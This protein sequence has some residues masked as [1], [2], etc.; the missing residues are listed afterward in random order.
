MNSVRAFVPLLLLCLTP[1]QMDGRTRAAA[2]HIDS[3]ERI[4]V[5]TAHP[6]DELVI[7]P[8]LANRCVHGGA[9]CALL[10]MT[11][12]N[13][14]GLGDIRAGEMAR[15]AALLNLRLTQWTH[16][17]V[18]ENVGDVWSGEAGARAT[19]VQ[20]IA[21]VIATEQPDMILTFDPNHGTT[22]HP[23]HREIGRLVLE[24]GAKNVFLIET[25][26]NFVGGGFELWNV[27]PQWAWTF[28]ANDDWRYAVRVAETHAT[29]FTPEQVESLRTLPSEQQRVWFMPSSLMPEC[30]LCPPSP[31]ATSTIR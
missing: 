13:A 9:S 22:R 10:V 14:A 4:L 8:L 21:N 1:V 20:R 11:T 26:A 2:S 27:A 30:T 19:L 5:I 31:I 3:A 6:D 29:Q 23:A 16:S 15:S 7:A 25:G 17:D 24:T 12:G 28:V 18:M